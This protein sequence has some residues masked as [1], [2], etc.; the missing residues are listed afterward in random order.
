MS[1]QKHPALLITGLATLSLLLTLAACND[2]ATPNPTQTPTPVPTVNPTPTP[3]P[4]MTPTPSPPRPT[5]KS[6]VPPVPTS[7]VRDIPLPHEPCTPSVDSDFFHP[8][9]GR[10]LHFHAGLI[11]EEHRYF[12]GEYG[13]DSYDLTFHYEFYEHFVAWT[14]SASHVVFDID[15]N[16]MDIECGVG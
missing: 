8:R 3:T 12:D 16:N 1:R 6:L 9:R 7:R 10:A 13:I 15:D 14:Q 4:T 2:A 5:P 11:P